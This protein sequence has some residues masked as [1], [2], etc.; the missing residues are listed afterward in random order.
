M[1]AHFLQKIF[2]FLLVHNPEFL[3]NLSRIILSEQ[4]L[5]WSRAEWVSYDLD[6]CRQ[7]IMAWG[8]MKRKGTNLKGS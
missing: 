3:E 8:N 5:M 1:K 7:L 6:T 4:I 2:L